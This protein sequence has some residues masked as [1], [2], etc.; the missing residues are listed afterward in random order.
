MAKTPGDV[1]FRPAPHL[2][3]HPGGCKSFSE[4]PAAGEGADLGNSH[5]EC[6]VEIP[7]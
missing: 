7:K 1:N 2:M 5:S 4:T 3:Y 6:A